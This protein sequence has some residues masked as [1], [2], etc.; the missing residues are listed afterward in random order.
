MHQEGHV[1]LNLALFAPVA[2]W[3]TAHDELQLMG[4]AMVGVVAMAPIPDIDLKLNIPHRG[5]THSVWFALLVGVAYAALLVVAGVGELSLVETASVGALSGVAGVFGH[6][7]GDMVTPMGVAPLEPV[8]SHYVGLGWCNAGDE[9][10]NRGL[11][12]AG[13]YTTA[14]A[15]VLGTVGVAPFLDPVRGLLA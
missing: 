8:S 14:G 9:R 12:Q 4:V 2:Y 15:V 6:I 3:L 1:G 11:F 13:I 5:P 10:V 7:L